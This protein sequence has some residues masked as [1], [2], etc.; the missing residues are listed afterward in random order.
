MQALE[1]W[2]SHENI[3]KYAAEVM[4]ALDFPALRSRDVHT[5]GG[6]SMEAL[7]VPTCGSHESIRSP[8]LRRSRKLQKYLPGEALK[9]LE[10]PALGSHKIS[11]STKVI[12]AFEVPVLGSHKSSVSTCLGSHKNSGST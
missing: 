7:E 6:R 11:L 2:G 4:K 3:R 12:K 8:C 5:R 1:Y 10:V 9:E